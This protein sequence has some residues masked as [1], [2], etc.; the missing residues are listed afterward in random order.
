M[1]HIARTPRQPDV[2]M[3][4]TERPLVLFAS[5]VADLKG[6][7]ERILLDLLANPAIRAALAVPGEGELAEIARQRGL[8]LRFIDLGAVAAVHRPPRPRDLLHAANEGARCARQLAKAVRDTGASLLHTNG[9]K[10]H[11]LGVASRLAH[12]VPVVAHVH[13][14]P[15]TRLEKTIWRGIAA[16]ATRT[17]L[18]SEPCY[19]GPLTRRTAVVAN[20]V[21]PI[22]EA[23]ARTLPETPTIGFVGRIHPFKGLHLLLDWF[24]QASTVRPTLRLLIRGRAE[25]EGAEYWASLQSQVSRLVAQGR[26]RVLGWAGPGEDPYAGID[27]LAVP[28]QTPDPSPLVVV[29]AMLRGIPPIGYPAGGIPALIGGPEHGAM[30]ADAAGFEAAL[31]RLL[32]PETYRLVS[33]AG[34]R[35]VRGTFSIERFWTNVNAQYAL[36]GLAM[37]R[38]DQPAGCA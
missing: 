15:H 4:G 34:A 33:A 19:P 17:M 2:P 37:A 12:R 13:D 35:R 31:T 14:I 25:Q 26:C 24:E 18:V 20:G 22:G 38:P 5:P 28:S 1:T 27:L 36:A 6:G 29:E 21:R 23:G 7:A 16:G 3:S 8:P 9:L 30:A 10:V 32:D 11:V